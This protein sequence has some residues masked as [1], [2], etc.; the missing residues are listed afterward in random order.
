MNKIDEE[1]C[2]LYNDIDRISK[3]FNENTIIQNSP[4]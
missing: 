3:P 2:N 1:I 4:K